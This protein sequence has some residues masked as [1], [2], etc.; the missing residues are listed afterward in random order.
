MQDWQKQNFDL[1]VE[2]IVNEFIV[3]YT[4]LTKKGKTVYG[5]T[6]VTDYDGL[7]AYMMASTL[8]SLK[9]KHKGSK[10]VPYGWMIGNDDG[11]VELGLNKFVKK[12]IEYYDDHIVPRFAD[13]NYDYSND[14]ND[15]IEMFMLGMK[16]AKEKLVAQF[17]A[18]IEAVIFLV[19]I[20]GE[21]DITV[22]SAKTINSESKNLR[23]LL[24][25]YDELLK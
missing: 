9:K 14:F 6:I 20:S 19:S 4:Y 2:S 3:L 25:F 24:K 12:H 1:L 17:G 21:D 13:G 15:N 7:T 16:S 18:H 8:E 5:V 11:D 22:E 10:W 23:K